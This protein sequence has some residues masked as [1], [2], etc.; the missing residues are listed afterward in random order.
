MSG[1][2]STIKVLHD[3]L[4]NISCASIAIECHGQPFMF[5]TKALVQKNVNN[6]RGILATSQMLCDNFLI[7][8]MVKS[9]KYGCQIFHACHSK[10]PVSTSYR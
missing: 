2:G 8:L 4:F 3:L 10:A 6:E 7:S 1:L 9:S 5:T